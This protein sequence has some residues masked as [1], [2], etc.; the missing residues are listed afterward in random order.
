MWQGPVGRGLTTSLLAAAIAAGTLLAASPAQAQLEGIIDGFRVV[1]PEILAP[2]RRPPRLPDLGPELPEPPIPPAPAEEVGSFVLAGVEIIGSTVYE[3]AELTPFYEDFLAREITFAQAEGIVAAIT[4]RYRED[5]YILSKAIARP[6]DLAFGILRIDIVEGFIETVTVEG[7]FAGRRSLLDGYIARIKAERPFTQSAL[8]TYVLLIDDLPG[9][10][11]RPSLRQLD[12]LTGSH[13]L[14]LEMAHDDFDVFASVDN[15][16]TRSIG[17]VIAQLSGNTYSLLGASERTGLFIYTV[18]QDNR[19]L[20]Y[21]ELLQEYPVG[22]AGTLVGFD[23][24]FS[25]IAAGDLL[26]PV[27]LKSEDIRLGFDASRPLL[28]R[29][30]RWLYLDGTFD[31]RNTEENL[32]SGN[33]YE[34]R[35]RSLR[36]GLRGFQIDRWRGENLLTARF[37]L[38]LDILDASDD[39]RSNTSRR[40][41]QT[42]YG[43]IEAEYLRWMALSDA[44]SVQAGLRGQ[45][46]FTGLLA[47]EEFRAGGSVYGRAY[48]PSEVAG[49]HGAAGYV[50]LRFDA[51]PL[52]PALSNIQTYM[53]YDLAQ[54]WDEDPLLGTTISSIASGG[55]GMRAELPFGIQGSLDI[56]RPLTAPVLQEGNNDVRFFFRLWASY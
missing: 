35:I 31:L 18:P 23:G 2:R 37:S 3:P 54:A 16:G 8:E 50:E 19:E 45:Y 51:Q 38:G 13:E 44:V 36:L 29:R 15:R 40:G 41:G 46:A 27:G 25:N 52:P 21:V 12:P 55:F 34:D 56:A 14:V 48:D 33:V 11:V 7:R 42:D 39:Q 22:D 53:F 6:Q 43:R 10:S 1:D 32:N 24:W 28:R 4:A 17:R 30:D 20:R 5:G 9:V 49:E 47:A 26:Q